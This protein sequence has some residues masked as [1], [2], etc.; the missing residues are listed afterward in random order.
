[1]TL[2]YMTSTIKLI[3]CIYISYKQYEQ[4]NLKFNVTSDGQYTWNM[5]H[6][7]YDNRLS[8]RFFQLS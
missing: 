4:N 6:I 7:M 1:M 2:T 8:I 5:G 3:K